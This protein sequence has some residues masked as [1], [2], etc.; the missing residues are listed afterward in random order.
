MRSSTQGYRHSRLPNPM[1]SRCHSS[2]SSQPHGWSS[3]PC[4]WRCA[5]ARRAGTIPPAA[6]PSFAGDR[7]KSAFGY[8]AP[9]PVP[10]KAGPDRRPHIPSGDRPRRRGGPIPS[11]PR[12][13]ERRGDIA[14]RRRCSRAV[15]S[16]VETR[17]SDE[18]A[19]LS[20]V[21]PK[22]PI[23]TVHARENATGIFSRSA[24]TAKEGKPCARQTTTQPA[25]PF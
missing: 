22:T 19:G 11:L 14:L 7:P 25:R 15:S 10:P 21:G 1:Q 12:A 3:P 23:G 4:W 16:A 20:R 24:S 9:P 17:P 2:S 13:P 5:V 6:A 18:R 8:R